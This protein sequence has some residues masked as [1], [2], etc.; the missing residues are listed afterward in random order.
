MVLNWRIGAKMIAPKP[1]PARAKNARP[2]CFGL[3]FAA[4]I[5]ML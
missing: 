5:A 4:L 1:I 3:A 2:C